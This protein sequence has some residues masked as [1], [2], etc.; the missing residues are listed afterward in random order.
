MRPKDGGWACRRYAWRASVGR[1]TGTEKRVRPL[2]PPASRSSPLMAGPVLASWTWIAIQE[3]TRAWPWRRTLALHRDRAR[4]RSGRGGRRSDRRRK[5]SAERGRPTRRSEHGGAAGRRGPGAKSTA[6]PARQGRGRSI[7][8]GPPAK[9]AP[10]LKSVP[11]AY[12]RGLSYDPHA[13]ARCGPRGPRNAGVPD[14]RSRA[15]VEV[16]VPV[17]RPFRALR[18]APEVAGDLGRLIAPPYDVIDEAERRMLLAR[19]PRNVVRLDLPDGRGRRP[20]SRRALSARRA[21]RSERGAAR[22]AV[23]RDPRPAHLRLRAGVQGARARS[24]SHPSRLLRPRRARTVRADG[25]R[26]HERT[27]PGAARGSLPPAAGDRTSTPA[28]WSR[29]TRTASGR[30]RGCPRGRRRDAADGRGRR[31]RRAIGIGCGSLTAGERRPGRGRSS[32]RV[33]RAPLTIADGHHRYETALRY[34]AEQRSGSADPDAPE[35]AWTSS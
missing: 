29:C 2:A 16:H 9:V 15:A 34:Q 19:D 26:A 28:R 5:P 25:I 32:T 3:P 18:Y 12:G 30:C 23:R 35:P 24:T 6:T 21:A 10:G 11:A 22:D 27:L 8:A 17:I 33:E 1:S 20:R 14:L 31:R 4:R 7:D 13:S